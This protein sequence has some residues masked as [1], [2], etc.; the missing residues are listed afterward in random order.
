M[1]RSSSTS[2]SRRGP[3]R[4]LLIFFGVTL[5]VFLGANLVMLRLYHGYRYGSEAGEYGKKLANARRA[6][7]ARGAIHTLFAGDSTVSVGITPRVLGPSAQNIAWSGFEPSELP[8]L[9]QH[10]LGFP[11]LPSDVYLGINPTFLSQNEWRS[12]LD[13]PLGSVLGDGLRSFYSDSNS[14]K[15]LVIMGG[16]AALSNRF[17][18][19]PFASRVEDAA[20]RTIV[21]D[22]G[23]LVLYPERRRAGQPRDDI[24]LPYRQANFAMLEQ[25]RKSLAARGVRV[26]WVFMPYTRGMERAL[27]EGA[28]GSR[29][30]S[31]YRAEIRRIFGG[32]VVD[33]S[34]SVADE[35]F[36]DE[37]HLT[38]AGAEQATLGFRKR[39][40]LAPGAERG[41]QGPAAG[42]P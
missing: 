9:E 26:S 2:G 32:D 39:V 7:A 23:L 19:P 6:Y 15:P 20:P 31:V 14:L 1:R 42:A 3:A 17:L 11:S 38:K 22:D 28:Q 5:A 10:I 12:T 36:R 21:E 33:L 34:G 35:M 27:R 25:F 40:A 13:L 29:F 8:L 18:A 16:L 24:T 30:S 41:R 37:V 4:F